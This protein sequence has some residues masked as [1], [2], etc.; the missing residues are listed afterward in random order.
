MNIELSLFGAF[1]EHA[2]Q[3]I[4]LELPDDANVRD[5][6]DAIGAFAR[7][8]WPTMR[9]GLLARSAFASEYRVLQDADPLPRDGRVALLPPVSGG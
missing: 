8:C 9:P 4:E 6:R 1:R 2:A 3:P 5:L 7:V